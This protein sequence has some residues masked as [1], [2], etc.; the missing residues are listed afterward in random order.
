MAMLY[1]SEP[2]KQQ[3]IDMIH[4]M[5]PT[6]DQLARVCRL[7]VEEQPND[8][9]PLNATIT[10]AISALVDRATQKGATDLLLPEFTNT[11]N[12]R[13]ID[14]VHTVSKPLDV[15]LASQFG[16]MFTALLNVL[17]NMNVNEIDKYT[18]E[19]D[20]SEITD[21]K[22]KLEN[23]AKFSKDKQMLALRSRTEI[24]V[25]Q[26]MARKLGYSHYNKLK[27]KVMYLY[28][29]ISN[30]YPVQQYK[31]D[32]RFERLLEHLY[33]QLPVDKRT[34]FDESLDHLTG[35]IFDTAYDCYI[36]NE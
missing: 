26:R 2:E 31:A 16:N 8:V 19:M 32:I 30:E 17:E 20:A 35:V 34:S 25:L 22:D 7:V 15:D 11:I 1:P 10:Q 3:L 28:F 13:T 9:Y 14:V 4:R 23:R 21:F 5:Q 36:F 18:S 24:A 29:R 12:K 33:E 27:K 6:I